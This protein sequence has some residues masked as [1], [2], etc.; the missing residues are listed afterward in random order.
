MTLG[1]IALGAGASDGKRIRSDHCPKLSRTSVAMSHAGLAGGGRKKALFLNIC[2]AWSDD[3]PPLGLAGGIIDSPR[4]GSD[5]GFARI[6]AAM[7]FTSAATLAHTRHMSDLEG[8]PDGAQ[9][10]ECQSIPGYGLLAGGYAGDFALPVQDRLPARRLPI[11]RC[12]CVA[13]RAVGGKR[14]M[15]SSSMGGRSSS[16]CCRKPLPRPIRQRK[17]KWS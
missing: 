1:V 15:T 5:T 10:V 3:L 7:T 2:I 11:T 17:A 4:A 6:A 13:A 16:G 12:A 14:A 8:G 9:L